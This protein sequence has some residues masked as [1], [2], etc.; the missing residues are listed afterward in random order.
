[1]ATGS[2]WPASTEKSIQIL[3]GLALRDVELTLQ[4]HDFYL[5]F[6]RELEMPFYSDLTA[7]IEAQELRVRSVHAP[8]M[9]THHGYSLRA[10]GEY[11]AHS[12]RTCHRLGSSVLVTH[13]YHLFKSYEGALGY[14]VGDIPDVWDALLPGVRVALRQAEAD[15]VAISME[16]IKVWQ[17][18]DTGFF[19]APHHVERFIDDVSHPKL[20]VTL[21]VIHAQLMGCLDQ[22]L[23]TLAH[24]IVNVHLA[25]LVPPARR[26]PPGE[27]ILPWRKLVPILRQLP[28]LQHVTIELTQAEPADVARSVDFVSRC[29]REV[30]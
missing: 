3:R 29:W 14:L 17:D 1:V 10:R 20:G 12:L 24:S 26:V 28:N 18:D 9:G 5:T 8:C 11:L 22:S 30:G 13:P 4:T 19:N 6:G 21:D 16:N 23:E 7:M 2:L 27:G 25:D 15:G